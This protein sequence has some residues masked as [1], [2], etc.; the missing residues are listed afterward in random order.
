VPGSTDPNGLCYS[1]FS[2]MHIEQLLP[3]DVLQVYARSNFGEA[4]VTVV[5]P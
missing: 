4:V 2:G 5:H 1:D 3:T